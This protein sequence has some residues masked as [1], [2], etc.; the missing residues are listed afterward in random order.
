MKA[1]KTMHCSESPRKRSE[2]AK[3]PRIIEDLGYIGK[4]KHRERVNLNE[5]TTKNAK[6][7]ESSTLINT[8]GD[9]LKQTALDMIK[10]L[11]NHK[12]AD[13]FFQKDAF[14]LYHIEKNLREEEMPFNSILQ[15][16]S[17]IRHYLSKLFYSSVAN[18]ECYTTIYSFASL[19]E[20]LYSKHENANHEEMNSV[21][22]LQVK[23]NKLHKELKTK[24][25]TTQNIINIPKYE[26]RLSDKQKLRILN[27]LRFLSEKEKLGIIGIIS[28]DISIENKVFEIE[29]MKLSDNTVCCLDKYVR[30]CLKKSIFSNLISLR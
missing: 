8:N 19:F 15:F 27:N 23:I 30:K 26:K 9:K 22:D 25:S 17:E 29:I 1:T 2:R 10:Q 24:Y 12:K 4:K 14:S 7:R 18:A 3:K 11:K 28:N 6:L 16:G 20:D 13:L 5:F 21:L